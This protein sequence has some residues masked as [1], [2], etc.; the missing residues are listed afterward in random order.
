MMASGRGKGPSQPHGRGLFSPPKPQAV[1]EFAIVSGES[2]RLR[3]PPPP[4]LIPTA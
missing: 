4:R 1:G 3:K 2:G